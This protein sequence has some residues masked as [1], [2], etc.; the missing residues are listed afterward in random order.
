MRGPVAPPAEAPAPPQ[1][2]DQGLNIGAANAVA[3]L[4]CTSG[5]APGAAGKKPPTAARRPP[6][7]RT[8]GLASAARVAAQR[9]R[10]R[11]R[12]PAGALGEPSTSKS[13]YGKTDAIC[14]RKSHKRVRMVEQSRPRSACSLPPI[15]SR[16]P[17]P[18]KQACARFPQTAPSP[19]YTHAD[20]IPL[21]RAI[22]DRRE[23]QRGALPNAC[24]API[25]ARD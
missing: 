13:G 21:S 19:E 20:R 6:A 23:W 24:D 4:R 22:N 12:R 15:D 25:D 16:R 17:S 10:C 11:A 2:V 8:R 3:H 1:R 14:A 7:P 9:R 18:R 5:A